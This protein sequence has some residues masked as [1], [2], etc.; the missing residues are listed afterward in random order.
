MPPQRI[1]TA[2]DE[3]VGL[4]LNAVLIDQKAAPDDDIGGITRPTEQPP[5]DGRC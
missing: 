2:A 4:V 1:D 3:S 5:A